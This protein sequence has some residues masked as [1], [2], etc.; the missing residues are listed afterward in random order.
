M[1]KGKRADERQ[2]KQKVQSRMDNTQKQDLQKQTTE[3]TND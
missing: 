1:A 2:T 3:K